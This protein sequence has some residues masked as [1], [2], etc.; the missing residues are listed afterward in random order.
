MKMKKALLAL[1]FALPFG[2]L[3]ENQEQLVAKYATL[4][5]SKANA[6]SLVTGLRDGEKVTLTRN[7][8]TETFTPKTG[9]MGYGN[10]DNALVLAEASLARQG[11]TNP[12][13]AQL[14]RSVMGILD[15]RA[16]G[17]GWGQIAQ[18]HGYKLGEAKR[19]DKAAPK[20]AKPEPVARADR[21]GTK[22]ERPEKS[23]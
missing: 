13:P 21:G 2:A 4:A 10:V 22:P 1:A 23:K 15:Q 9:K 19:S 14:E 8:T 12:T 11:I 18:T 16:D 3:A 7:G 5:G 20:T 17:K 6:T